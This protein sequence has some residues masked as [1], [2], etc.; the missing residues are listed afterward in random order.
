[1]KK[2]LFAT[3]ILAL[4]GTAVQAQEFDDIYYNP[5]K[6]SSQPVESKKKKSN[7]IKDFSSID[8]DTYNRRG[9]YYES[10]IDTIGVQAENG[11]DFV[12]TQKIQKFYNPTVVVDNA[13]ILADVI[14]NSYGNVNI[15]FEN[16]L[17]YFNSIYGWP[18][19]YDYYSWY[20]SWRWNSS[21][22]WS[23][24]PMWGFELWPSWSLGPSW[25]WG[26]SFGWGWGWNYGPSWG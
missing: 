2:I 19:Y 25:A 21:Y 13:D 26:P 11:E 6:D 14:D 5:K 20:P 8:V 10:P 7:Y 1:M 23:Y 22:Y 18:G 12:Y 16:G 3:A 15:I 17:P 4:A 24:N 9:Q